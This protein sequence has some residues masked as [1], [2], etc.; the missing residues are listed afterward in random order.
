MN[1]L[2][3]VELGWYA[4]FVIA[5]VEDA[6]VRSRLLA[7]G[8]PNTVR[9]CEFFISEVADDHPTIVVVMIVSYGDWDAAAEKACEDASAAAWDV[10]GDLDAYVDV[11]CR[12][13]N[14][15]D[16]S[17]GDGPWVALDVAC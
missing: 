1:C 6:E 16:A 9:A 8:I 12:T 2:P 17:R 3:P 4:D 14:E 10:L 13:K 5:L 11:I 15:H 7:A